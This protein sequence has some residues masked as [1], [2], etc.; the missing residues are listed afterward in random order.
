MKTNSNQESLRQTTN[1]DL[2]E[3]HPFNREVSKTKALEASMK[4][5]GWIGAYPMHCITNGNGKFKIVGGHHRFTVARKL[6]IPVKYVVCEN[7]NVTIHELER[8]TRG[9]SMVDYLTS[10]CALDKE[11]YLAVRTYHEQTGINVSQCVSLIAGES[12][13]SHNHHEKFKLGTYKTGNISHAMDV[14]R[15]VLKIKSLGFK[16][17]TSMMFVG[18]ISKVLYIEKFNI[19]AFIKRASAN[20]T[21]FKRQSSVKDYLAMIETIY[22][23]K[24]QKAKLP[25]VFLAQQAADKRNA[26]KTKAEVN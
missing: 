10:Y 6:G 5:N 23:Y 18:A 13:N 11:Q 9:W 15:V 8:A 4:K 19:D 25:I 2:F 14:A 7:K 22:N 21:M 17:A 24:N 3:L 12:A 20:S 26:V 16:L 1:Y